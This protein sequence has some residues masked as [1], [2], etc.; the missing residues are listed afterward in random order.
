MTENQLLQL[1][2]EATSTKSTRKRRWS[3]LR[4]WREWMEDNGLSPN[5]AVTG[6][7]IQEF[8]DLIMKE[9]GRARATALSYLSIIRNHVVVPAVRRSWLPISAEVDSYSGGNPVLAKTVQEKIR[10]T[11]LIRPLLDLLSHTPGHIA[12]PLLG[13]STDDL[14]RYMLRKAQAPNSV[15]EKAAELA[16][17]IDKGKLDRGLLYPHEKKELLWTRNDQSLIL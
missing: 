7:R 8:F 9:K 2:A 14:K 10:R 11:S 17:A 12:A 4:N 5:E 16:Y 6:K 15:L 1:I 3:V 13:I